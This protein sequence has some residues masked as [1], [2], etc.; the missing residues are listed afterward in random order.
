MPP[1]GIPAPGLC[2]PW[3]ASQ[4]GVKRPGRAACLC[5]LIRDRGKAVKW[6]GM[7]GT[8][9]PVFPEFLWGGLAPPLGQGKGFQSSLAPR[10]L[11]WF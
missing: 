7:A 8:K 11:P 1:E 10:P 4:T 5:L 9:P 6:A 2:L 3:D